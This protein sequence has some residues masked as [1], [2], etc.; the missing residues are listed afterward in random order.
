MLSVPSDHRACCLFAELIKVNAY[1]EQ[2]AALTLPVPPYDVVR[3]DKAIKC[4]T[5]Y[6]RDKALAMMRAL[7]LSDFDPIT[8]SRIRQ[9]C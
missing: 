8:V 4:Y 5:K 6:G 1:M 7:K 3:V 9:L 2:V